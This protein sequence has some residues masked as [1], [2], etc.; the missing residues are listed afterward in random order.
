MSREEMLKHA[1]VYLAS[2]YTS[3]RFSKCTLSP[4]QYELHTF[5]PTGTVL[6]AGSL[7]LF[8]NIIVNNL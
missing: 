5:K 7:L 6:N 4:F 1:F 8:D 3:L 2:S